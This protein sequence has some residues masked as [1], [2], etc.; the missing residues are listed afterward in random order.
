MKISIR[1]LILTLIVWHFH[2]ISFSQKTQKP[3]EG[4]IT[5]D[6]VSKGDGKISP[7]VVAMMPKSCEYIVKGAKVKSGV[8]TLGLENH[9]IADGDTKIMYLV[10]TVMDSNMA[11]K[12]SE[13]EW[14][15]IKNDQDSAKQTSSKPEVKY[16]EATKK[17]CGYLCN[18][19]IIETP[20]DDGTFYQDTM[21]VAKELK[22]SGLQFFKFSDVDYEG[23]ALEFSYY[24][25]LPERSGG[26]VLFYHYKASSVKKKRISAKEF[27]LP[28][29]CKV[30]SYSEFLEFQKDYK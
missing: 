6:V 24:Y 20:K 29:K 23:T 11:I 7:A 17:L 21:W 3:F 10:T 14:Q 13:D 28:E 15:K 16:T 18:Q 5:Y 2:Q 30:M 1:L 25:P 8:S 4:I 19:M 22:S 12:Y 9:Y 27:E 26:G